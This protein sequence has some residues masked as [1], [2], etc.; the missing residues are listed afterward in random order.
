MDKA[1]KSAI[2][3]KFGRDE[4]DCGSSEVQIAIL[5][6]RITEITEHLKKFKK[7]NHSRKGL[8]DLVGRRRKLL[9]YLLNNDSEKHDKVVKELK[10]RVR[11]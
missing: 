5:T 4:N 3:K 10:L 6:E 8:I 1:T 7:D 11:K 9:K 2:I